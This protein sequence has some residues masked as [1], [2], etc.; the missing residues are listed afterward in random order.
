M[1][2]LI[3]DKLNKLEGRKLVDCNK[4]CRYWK[5]PHLETACVLSDV[6]SVRKGEPCY[7]YQKGIKDGA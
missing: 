3:N 7:E 6:F 4:T 2:H 1:A 5:F